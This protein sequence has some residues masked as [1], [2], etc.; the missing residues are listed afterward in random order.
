MDIFV[1]GACMK[2]EL[3]AMSFY[4]KGSR[5]SPESFFYLYAFVKKIALFMLNM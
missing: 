3:R 4:V 5:F 1:F 2:S